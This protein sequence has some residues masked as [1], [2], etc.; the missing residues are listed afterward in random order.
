MEDV[1][2][3]Q[4][5]HGTIDYVLSNPSR[6]ITEI[7]G[8]LCQHFLHPR[9]RAQHYRQDLTQKV[10]WHEGLPWYL[11]GKHL[12]HADIRPVFVARILIVCRNDCICTIHDE[13]EYIQRSFL[14]YAVWGRTNKRA[15]RVSEHA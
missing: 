10:A 15:T 2:R 6:S 11:T 8:R 14:Q 9:G 3:E 13:S 1:F 7:A 12:C 5:S 4:H